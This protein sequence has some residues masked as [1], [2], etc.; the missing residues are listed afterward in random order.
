[1][2]ELHDAEALIVGVK[3]VVEGPSTAENCKGEDSK[4]NKLATEK[5]RFGWALFGGGR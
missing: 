1:M 2:G 4:G 3:I 5:I